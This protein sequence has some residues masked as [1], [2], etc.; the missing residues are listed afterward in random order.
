VCFVWLLAALA[1]AKSQ[2]KGLATSQTKAK[3]NFCVV[4]FQKQG[5]DLLLVAFGGKL[6]TCHRL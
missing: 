3:S 4:H 1:F 6:P 5:D 2:P